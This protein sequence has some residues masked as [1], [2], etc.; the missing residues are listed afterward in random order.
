MSVGKIENMRRDQFA[1]NIVSRAKC[2]HAARKTILDTFHS[3]SISIDS[4]V[5]T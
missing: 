1:D 3:G 5:R 4:G 2:W